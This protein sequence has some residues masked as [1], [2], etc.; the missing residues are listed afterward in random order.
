MR[1]KEKHIPLYR[2]LVPF[3]ILFFL[4]AGLIVLVYAS[5]KSSSV[6]DPQAQAYPI[7]PSKSPMVSPKTGCISESG[8]FIPE[9]KCVCEVEGNEAA[10]W[11]KLCLYDK[12]LTRRSNSCS[13]R[14][15]TTIIPETNDCDTLGDPDPSCIGQKV[16]DN[17]G[18]NLMCTKVTFNSQ[19]YC[20]CSIQTSKNQNVS[21]KTNV[22]YQQP[23]KDPTLV[24]PWWLEHLKAFRQTFGI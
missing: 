16:G 8:K 3:L 14:C 11:D 6:Y 18:G 22:K 23:V 12:Y 1:R 10:D 9:D 20:E 13:K 24:P 7:F 15:V 5:T 4:S 21:P 17:C 2:S 19:T